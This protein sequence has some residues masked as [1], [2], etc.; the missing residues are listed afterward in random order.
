MKA[1]R[2]IRNG[3]SLSLTSKAYLKIIFKDAKMD[4]SQY[5]LVAT[6]L[7]VGN[8]SATRIKETQ[9]VAVNHLKTLEKYKR[10]VFLT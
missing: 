1:K 10:P 2:A 7:F 5:L 9:K 8:F 6:Y 4:C 3:H